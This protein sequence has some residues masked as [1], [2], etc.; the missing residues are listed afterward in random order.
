MSRVQDRNRRRILA[1]TRA[2]IERDG[3]DAMSMRIVADQA[4]V[5]VRTLYNLFGDRNGLIRALVQDSLDDVSVAVD[6]IAATDPLERIWEVVG[7]AVDTIAESLPRS[8]VGVVVSDD[9]LLWQLS[10]RWPVQALLHDGLVAGTRADLFYDDVAPG[11]IVDHVG[12]VLLHL[13][14]RWASGDVDDAQLRAGTLHAVDV[15]LLAVAR[16]T[17]RKKVRDHAADLGPLLPDVR[18][19]GSD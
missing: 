8:V 4:G 6:D 17:V 15:S 2:Y 11:M 3:I 1:D 12:M 5:S 10:G 16:P 7:T 13:L 9:E 14:R 19:R 18:G